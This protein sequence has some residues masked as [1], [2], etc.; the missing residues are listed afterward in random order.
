MSMNDASFPCTFLAEQLLPP[1]VSLSSTPG[2]TKRLEVFVQKETTINGSCEGMNFMKRRVSWIA[3]LRQ[4]S[5]PG[6]NKVFVRCR[7][8]K[9][10]YRDAVGLTDRHTCKH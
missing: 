4:C 3:L 5:Y 2:N 1:P 6:K 7:S 8:R 9:R 10:M